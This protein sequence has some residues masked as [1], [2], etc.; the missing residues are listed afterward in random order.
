A[1]VTT[2]YA[3]EEEPT[4]LILNGDFAEGSDPWWLTANLS[5]AVADGEWCIDVPGGTLN[6]WDAIVGQNDLPL[7]EGESYELRFT[8]RASAP[9]SVRALVQRDVDPW[10]VQ[11][12]EFPSLDT[13]A[14]AYS[15][16]F[17]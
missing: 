7:A 11:L 2:A 5:G 8:A 4:N 17:T 1:A 15:Y 14:Q 16:T 10:P 9:V 6:A 13:E 3:Q 12:E